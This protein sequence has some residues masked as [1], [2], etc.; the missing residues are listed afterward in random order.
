MLVAREGQT[1]CNQ[2]QRVFNIPVQDRLVVEGEGRQDVSRGGG[3]N[4]LLL[5]G[6]GADRMLVLHGGGQRG[7]Q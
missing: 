7:C 2:N 4:R 3:A 6:E 1:G 5:E